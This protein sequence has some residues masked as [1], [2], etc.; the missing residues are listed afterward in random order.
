MHFLRKLRNRRIEKA[1]AE[2]D[3]MD[4]REF[5]ETTLKGAAILTTAWLA[6]D[7]VYENYGGAFEESWVRDY[8]KSDF[9][10][11]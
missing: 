8:Y 6:A 7:V 3:G 11:V 9:V 5:L 2:A 10:G 4:R 1:A